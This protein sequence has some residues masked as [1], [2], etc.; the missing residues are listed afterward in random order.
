MDEAAVR[1]AFERDPRGGSALTVIEHGDV[2]LELHEGWRDTARTVPWDSDT[3][4]NVWSV[5]KPV[6]ALA[7]VLLVQRGRVQLDDPV[8]KHWPEF[9]SG[10]TLRH[11]LTHTSGLASFPVPRPAQAWADWDLL[12]ADLAAA[13]PEWPPGEVPAEHAFTYGHLIGEVVRR[14]DGRTA[15]RFVAEEIAHP[16]AAD[17]VFGV[18]PD[19]LHRCA[20]LEFGD[21]VRNPRQVPFTQRP[22]GTDDLAVLNSDLWRTASIPAIN[23][24]STATAM[25]RFYHALMTSPAGAMMAQ[26]LVEGVDRFIGSHTVWG[27]G[28]QFEPDGTWGMGGL[29][30]NAAWA[31]PARGRAIAYVTR[32][33]GDFSTVDRIEQA[34]S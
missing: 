23:L 14:V 18:G 11:V 30:G 34:L 26:P 20:E 13:T 9:T 29:G 16:Y 21:Y 7:L 10:A 8:A 6:I 12:C 5:G 33:M 27:L 25:A 22:A 1:E 32:Q 24:H 31:D 17:F 28:V 3:L 2:V 19:Q 15:A 4:V